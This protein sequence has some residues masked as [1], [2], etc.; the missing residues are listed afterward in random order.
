MAFVMELTM[1]KYKIEPYFNMK[2]SK[3]YH[4]FTLEKLL[5]EFHLANAKIKYLID[6]GNCYVNGEVASSNTLLRT[7]DY[8]TIDISNFEHLDFQPEAVEINILY[9]D[10]YLLV[11][12]KPSGYIIYPDNRNATGTIA[13]FIADYYDKNNL[14]LTIRH[15][16][17]LDSA[18]SGCLVFAKDLITHSAMSY[19]FESKQVEKTYWTLVEGILPKE[20]K[21]NFPIGKD[22][23][24]N[25]KMIVS[26]T[27]KPA[28]TTYKPLT[29]FQNKTLLEVKIATGRTHQIRVHLATIGHP[30]INDTLYGSKTSG[31][32]M[33]HCKSIS[34]LHPITKSKVYIE[35]PLPPDFKMNCK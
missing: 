4:N 35:A 22:R 8:L 2:I 16:H 23:H 30:I 17:R 21:I 11:I 27:G 14:D 5:K 20:G 6:N 32:V 12:N 26:N 3:N 15:C 25:G 33:L 18:T 28:L 34:F 31:R 1:N 24:V 9:E 13:N 10:E 19:L 7:N 29:V